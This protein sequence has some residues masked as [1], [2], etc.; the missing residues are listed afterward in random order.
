M[1]ITLAF[2]APDLGIVV[3]GIPHLIGA[4][5]VLAYPFLRLGWANG[6]LGLLLVALGAYLQTEHVAAT[7]PAGILLTPPSGI[8]LKGFYMPD[9]R[10]LLP[11][12]G[13]VLVGLF[14]GNTAHRRRSGS[15]GDAHGT[16]Y[17][18]PIAVLGRHT[19]SSTPSTSPS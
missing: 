15:T 16:S 6:L 5:I 18:A 11:W 4:S 7:G 9:Y 3:F 14:F 1:L 13:V 8:E 17:W 10:P 12:F 2:W 19:S